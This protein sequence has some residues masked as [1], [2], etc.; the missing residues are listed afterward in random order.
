MVE[1]LLVD[2]SPIF[3][4]GL[5]AV[6][7]EAPREDHMEVIAEC[8]DCTS[9]VALAAKLAPDLV[10]SDL[11][12][13]GRNGIEL[14]R[15]LARSAPAVR[16]LILASYGPEAIVHQALA[17]GAAG[18]ALKQESAAVVLAAI[19]SAGRGELVLPPGISQPPR[20]QARAN[21]EPEGIQLL[22]RREREVFDLAVWGS[23]NKQIAGRLGISTKTVETHR[24]HINRKLRVH[25]SADLVRLAS[26]LGLLVPAPTQGP[27]TEGNGVQAQ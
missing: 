27:R 2:P 15:E 14:V 19:K 16:V 5:K 12:L 8:G 21:G 1:L 18:Y 3:R 17:A 4:A 6:V 13:G 9:G 10:V 26:L 20:H 23:S 24:G 7:A 11:H 22:S 25:T